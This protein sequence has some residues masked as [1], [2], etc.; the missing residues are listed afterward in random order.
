MFL[1]FLAK[2]EKLLTISCNQFHQSLSNC[3]LSLMEMIEV[4]FEWSATD[5]QAIEFKMLIR[6]WNPDQI[7]M[8]ANFIRWKPDAFTFKVDKN[9][10]FFSS[11]STK[12]DERKALGCDR[13]WRR[14]SN[15]NRQFLSFILTEYKNLNSG[16]LSLCT[17]LDHVKTSSCKISQD[18]L[19]LQ[20]NE[21]CNMIVLKSGP[22]HY[23]SGKVWTYSVWDG[24][25]VTTFGPRVK[26]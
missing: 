4:S 17:R 15:E 20:E 23:F 13:F 11:K 16:R 6:I 5:D 19:R 1:E 10:R 9:R 8:F 22:R 7:Q 12:T 3:V 25:V 21:S 14:K 2:R 26:Y 18:H 24:L